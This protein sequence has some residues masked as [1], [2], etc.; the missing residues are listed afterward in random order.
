M[1]LV[2]ALG[3]RQMAAQAKY[4]GEANWKEVCARATAK[5]LTVVEGGRKGCDSERLYYGFGGTPDREAALACGYYERAHAR[6]DT[7]DPFYGVGV[8]SMLY[9]N[10][11]G[12]QRNYDL[13]IRFACEN[14]WAA[15]AEMEGRIGHLEYLRDRHSQTT[16]FD[17]CDDATS[18]LMEG[19]CA[20]VGERAAQAKRE[21]RL[22]AISAGWTPEVRQAFQA[23]EQAEQAF[24]EAHSGKEIDLSG[25]GRAAFSIEGAEKVHEQFLADL[26]RL[27][28]GN[29]P[30]AS[31]VDYKNADAKLNT[32]Y[33]ALLAERGKESKEER[34]PGSVEV[35]GIRE[36]ERVWIKFRDAWVTFG[37]VANPGVSKEQVG[38]WITRQRVEQMKEIE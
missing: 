12:V 19:A 21:A 6:P 26:E 5:P 32:S 3:Q 25:T 22:K 30:A 37:S 31:E 2:I 4:A 9:A 11:F 7:G 34:M 23:L 17:L 14:T 36:T 38:T 35:S 13:A 20:R 33:R 24:A 15:D 8:L 29:V 18:G 27:V 28:K 1:A 10:G 16:D